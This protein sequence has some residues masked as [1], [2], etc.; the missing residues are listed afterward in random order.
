[1]TLSTEI[2]ASQHVALP[3]EEDEI[4][5]VGED[6]PTHGRFYGNECSTDA[7]SSAESGAEFD[8]SGADSSGESENNFCADAQ[9]SRKGQVSSPPTAALRYMPLQ[10]GIMIPP[11]N[12]HLLPQTLNNQ[13]K[14]SG[15]QDFRAQ[16]CASEPVVPKPVPKPGPLKCSFSID[17]II[18]KPSP[19]TPQSPNPHSALFYGHL[20]SGSAAGLVPTLVQPPRTPFCPPAMLNA[21]ALINER[22]RLSYP[23]C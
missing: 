12:Y 10:E 6:K 14:S 1:M 22:L 16:H 4:D 21:A 9:P 17:S 5:I 19:V 2:E 23:R 8:S 3:L 13:G 20:V 15:A 18:S 11:S 7:G